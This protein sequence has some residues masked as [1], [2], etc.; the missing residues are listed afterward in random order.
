MSLMMWFMGLYCAV[1][2]LAAT[3]SMCVIFPIIPLTIAV[4]GTASLLAVREAVRVSV[5]VLTENGQVLLVSVI[6]SMIAYQTF[7]LLVS[8]AKRKFA[9]R[10]WESRVVPVVEKTF[11]YVE[12]GPIGC[13]F[14]ANLVYLPVYHGGKELRVPLSLEMLGGLQIAPPKGPAKEMTIPVS[15]YNEATKLPKGV[16]KIFDGDEVRGMGSRITI[17]RSSYLVTSRHV[18]TGCVSTVYV[19]TETRKMP[20]DRNEFKMLPVEGVDLA[21]VEL[22]ASMWSVLGVTALKT[23]SPAVGNVIQ[24][25]GDVNG[26]LAFST[27][28]VNSFNKLLGVHAASTTPG[29][30]GTPLM[31]EG[32][33]IGVHVGHNGK[34]NEFVRVHE[35]VSIIAKLFDESPV[36]SF[37][38][39]AI[40]FDELTKNYNSEDFT[41][42]RIGNVPAA[43]SDTAYALDTLRAQEKNF[44]RMSWYEMSQMEDDDLSDLL[45]KES[46]DVSLNETSG[47]QNTQAPSSAIEQTLPHSSKS[48]DTSSKKGK[49]KAKECPSVD[50]GAL[51]SRLEELNN[52]VT[53]ISSRLNQ[54][55]PS[56]QSG[57]GQKL[58]RR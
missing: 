12:A 57:D 36:G 30:S 21:I 40:P 18:L 20:V 28:Q 38:S 22:P 13:D 34:L 19:G 42:I 53:K 51:Q 2:T 33:V 7:R 17:G 16:V 50:V 5:T 14:A 45:W 15:S 9:E 11:T 10:N 27:G 24:A 48:E 49:K 32:M 44:K 8:F 35:I 55:S 29:W 3:V 54:P 25:F 56:S 26:K 31:N 43:F 46:S 4:V 41:V 6:L 39:K 23:K 58:A 1:T 37:G 47:L 52:E